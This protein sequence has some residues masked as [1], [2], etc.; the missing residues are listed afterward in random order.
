M[1]AAKSS[2]TRMPTIRRPCRSWS[3]PLSRSTLIM[4]AE[5]LIERAAPRNIASV[6]LQPSSVATS[7][8]SAIMK[9]IS[10]VPIIT[11]RGP[12]CRMRRQP[13]SSPMA[14]SSIMKPSSA[15]RCMLSVWVTGEG[16]FR[17]GRVYGP[18]M[19]PAMRYPSTGGCLSHWNMTIATPATAII[20]AK[21][22]TRTEPSNFSS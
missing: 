15:I 7:Y 9:M 22:R 1:T 2:T 4:I 5:L 13:N 11:T 18:T 10:T 3:I 17:S 19:R 12:S 20:V 8:P 14:N 16:R 6:V 21:S